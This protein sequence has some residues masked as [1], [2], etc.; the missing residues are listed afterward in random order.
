MPDRTPLES[1]PQP[2]QP[3]ILQEKQQPL[4]NDPKE[5]PSKPL[6][7]PV[8]NWQPP[9]KG[10]TP[11]SP[12]QLTQILGSCG[13]PTVAS[14]LTTCAAT[15][16]ARLV[17]DGYVNSRVF[18]LTEPSPGALE[19][20][21][22]RIAELRIKSTDLGLQ[23]EIKQRLNSLINSV[24]HLPSL[25]KALVN[26]RTIP[27]VGQ[28]SGNLGRLGSDATQAVLNLTID[29]TPSPWMGEASIRNDGN[30]GTGAYRSV[31]TVVKNSLLKRND[32][33]LAYLELNGDADPEL[34]AAI[35]SISY[36]WPLS[37]SW[38]LTGS[39]GWSRRWMVEAQDV[40]HEISFR[41]FQGM[42]QIEKTLHQSS[43]QFWSAFASISSSRNDAYL[44]GYSAPLV[45]GGGLDGWLR[46]GY[47]KAGINFGGNT[48]SL[49]WGGNIYG[50]QGIAGF[51]TES[52]L[53]ELAWYGI[54]SG[55]AKAIGGLA[56]L[57]W[58]IKPNV[59]LNLRG[60]Y[61]WAFNKLPSDMGFSIG[62]DLGLIGLPGTL[63]SGDSGWLAKSELVVT[64][65]LKNNQ[66][67]QIV[68]FFGIG[69]VHTDFSELIIEDTVGSA[70]ILGRYINGAW[71]ME[72]G[73][74][75]S[76]ETNDNP[77]LWQDW[78]VGNGLYANLKYHF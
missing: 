66:A 63:I 24:L 30:A 4:E 74:V 73:W 11:Y 13:R 21:E 35:T 22:G 14:T 42:A 64:P 17:R 27:G 36:S 33:F 48:N 54:D 12:E 53:K 49:A 10:T 60:A 7:I 25:E 5:P 77:G 46:S 50:L 55:E 68:P 23:Q 67:F 56:N 8:S 18:T 16:T 32:T 15:L 47:L 9:I 75:D 70:G 19:V 28:I 37:E 31:A 1:R 57:T 76:F 43:N 45:L 20:V 2:S 3:I 6:G 61:Q 69:G 71:S 72:L 29:V 44:A 40:G 59:S 65:W 26:V 34:G 62:S 58:R 52:Q 51:S 38:L 78:V 41:Q 39:M